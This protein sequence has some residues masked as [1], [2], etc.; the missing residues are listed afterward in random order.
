MR[1]ISSGSP[2]IPSSI[3]SQSSTSA[4]GMRWYLPLRANTITHRIIAI[5]P[6]GWSADP[7]EDHYGNL[8]CRLLPVFVEDRHLPSLLME[9]SLALCSAGEGSLGL[10]T[11][12]PDLHGRGR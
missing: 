8:S 5:D 7:L 10:K 1:S 2:S 6:S 12:G 3:S 11:L 9:Q 4:S